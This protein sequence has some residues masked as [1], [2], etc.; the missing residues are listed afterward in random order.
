[1]SGSEPLKIAAA[2]A[3]AFA[4]AGVSDAVSKWVYRIEPSG[5]GV[6]AVGEKPASEVFEQD[7]PVVS[8]LPAADLARGEKLARSCAVCHSFEED[9]HRKTGPGLW[10][11]VGAPTARE[12]RFQYSDAM[13]QMDGHWDISTLDAYL[14]DPDTYLPGTTMNYIGLRDSEDRAALIAWLKTLS[15]EKLIRNPGIYV[16]P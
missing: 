13:A 16:E 12:E 3:I 1:M 9:G 7:V 14:R 2:V 11:I 10:D 5:S 8:L 15:G 4:V 6:V